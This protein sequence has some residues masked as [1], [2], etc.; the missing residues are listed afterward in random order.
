MYQ[1]E[2]LAK[3]SNPSKINNPSQPAD[4]GLIG[5]KLKKNKPVCPHTSGYIT[6][7]LWMWIVEMCDDNAF[8]MEKSQQS[9]IV[10]Q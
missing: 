4:D 5:T 2:L 9:I 6:K 10:F 3:T 1:L 8:K 7:I